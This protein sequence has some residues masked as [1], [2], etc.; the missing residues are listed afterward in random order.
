MFNDYLPLTIPIRAANCRA[1]NACIRFDRAKKIIKDTM[2]KKT[3]HA[4]NS[5]KSARSCATMRPQDCH[6][7]VSADC[8]SPLPRCWRWEG[9]GCPVLWYGVYEEERFTLLHSTA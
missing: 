2:A 7:D 4:T 3:L 1:C 6:A 5:Q 9:G 8:E